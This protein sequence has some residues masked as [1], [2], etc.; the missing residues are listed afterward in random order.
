MAIVKEYSRPVADAGR[1]DILE[2]ATTSTG[3]ILSNFG[4]SRI[5][6]SGAAKTF[7]IADPVLGLRKTV[8]IDSSTAAT[9]LATVGAGTFLASGGSGG[10]LTSSSGAAGTLKSV[11]L[12]GL[13]SA[14]WAVVSETTGLSYA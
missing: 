7:Q 4:V 10:T 14:N 3:V 1:I 6:Q 9:A 11:N 5:T 2:T 13:S 8:L 12:I